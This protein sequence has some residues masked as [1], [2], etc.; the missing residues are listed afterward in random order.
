[1]SILVIFYYPLNTLFLYM[2]EHYRAWW[3][4]DKVSYI[5]ATPLY[6]LLFLVVSLISFPLEF[7]GDRAHPGLYRFE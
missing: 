4:D 1:M 7:L 5:L 6:Y 2:Q 3:K